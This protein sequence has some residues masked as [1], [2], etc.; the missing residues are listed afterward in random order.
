[1][2]Q[3]GGSSSTLVSSLLAVLTTGPADGGRFN[4]LTVAEANLDDVKLM[5]SQYNE[6]KPKVNFVPLRLD[7]D[8][9]EQ[10]LNDDSFDLIVVTPDQAPYL[11]G[12]SLLNIV[13]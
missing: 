2:L 1:M 8:A 13:M 11:Q 7:L 5:E 10:G 3:V 12:G 9:A 4:R 6:W